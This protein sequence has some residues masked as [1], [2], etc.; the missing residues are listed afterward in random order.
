MPFVS[1][2]AIQMAET[3]VRKEI[4]GNAASGGLYARGMANEGYAGGYAQALQDV[5]LL[6]SGV[7]PTT[8]GYW[9]ARNDAALARAIDG[10]HA[11]RRDMIRVPAE[12]GQSR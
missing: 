3:A 9:D 7:R 11:G 4:A 10:R 6:A 2:R 1:K 12:P 5:L 8:R